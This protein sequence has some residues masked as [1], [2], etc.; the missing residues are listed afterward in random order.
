M[1]ISGFTRA[2]DVPTQAREKFYCYTR[3]EKLAVSATSVLRPQPE[4]ASRD[5]GKWPTQRNTFI[6]FH[7]AD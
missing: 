1:I 2:H 5:S 4:D 7:P 3:D 6:A